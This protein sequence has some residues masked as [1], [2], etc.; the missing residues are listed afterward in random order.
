[1]TTARLRALGIIA[2]LIVAFI[3]I[4][5]TIGWMTLSEEQRQ[6]R[7]DRWHDEDG[8]YR[9]RSVFGDL[10]RSWKRWAE[11]DRSK[12]I[13]LGLDLRGG[14]HMV[15]GFDI[16]ELSQHDRELYEE[17]NY[18]EA[19][20]R[21]EIQK[22]IL[23][24]V[25]RR[26]A[27]FEA[28][29]PVI[30]TLGDSQVQIQLPG[31]KD[32]S[33]AQELI[34]KTAFLGFHI[35]PNATDDR[36]IDALR[37]INTAYP[38]KFTGFLLQ[39][40]PGDPFYRVEEANYPQLRSLLTEINARD[41]LL[42]EGMVMAFGEGDGQVRH[43]YLLNKEPDLTG[44]GLN[45][46]FARPDTESLSGQWMVL[47]ENSGAA[48]TDFGRVTG[49]NIGRNMAI[50]VDGVVVSAPVIQSRISGSGSISGNFDPY[51]AQDLAIALNSG[52]LP[53]PIREDF[54]GVVGA[55]LGE[56]SVKSGVTSALI[57]IAIVMVFMILY[58]R[59]SGIVANISLIVNAL[60]VLAALAY[61]KA[62]LTL[63][64][65]AGLILTV[66]MAVD[67]NVLI[68]ERIREE[69]RNGRS[70]AASIESG[71]ARAQVTILDANITTLIAAAV[72][73]QFG[74]GPIE[75]FAVTLSIGV[76]TSVFTAL[77]LSRAIFDFIVNSNMVSKLGMSSIIKPDTT[78]GFMGASRVAFTFSAICLIGGMSFFFYRGSD[79]FGVDFTTGTNMI[80]HF[81]GNREI[82]VEDVRSKLAEKGMTDVRVQEYVQGTG[83]AIGNGFSIHLGDETGTIGGEEGVSSTVS[84]RAQ[85]ALAELVLDSPTPTTANDA[86]VL[87][88]V[89]TVGPAV[90]DQLKRDAIIAILYSMV[91][92]V[93]YLWYR[94]EYK[95]A[96]AAII[97]VLHDVLFTLGVFAVF[98]RELSLPVIAALLTIIGY[99]LNDTI[100]VFDRIRED[101][102]LYRGR[103]M[104]FSKILNISINQT[105]SRTL[106]TSVTTLFV[107]VVLAVFGGEAIRDF[108]IALSAGVLVG[109]YS[110]IFVASPCVMLLQNWETARNKN[111]LDDDPKGGK[112]GRR[113]RKPKK[114][115]EGAQKEATA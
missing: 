1:M 65:I 80:V 35:V 9:E 91:C 43:L 47:F 93:I 73:F 72:L 40:R 11:F 53:V 92:I 23:N 20:I 2:V 56:E 27:E 10:A 31:E 111:K 61:F 68:F 94:F 109:T 69:L 19:D 26:M 112:G 15:V 38:D 64:G 57:G 8:T 113:R 41:D 34:T 50:V 18:T 48:A 33:R 88:R 6:E 67:A 103:E 66:G 52:S 13:T 54:T 96:F 30:Q 104:K 79:N 77:I 87:D 28:K 100:V 29:E 75:S 102:Q 70:L 76:L 105:L 82:N 17:S 110:S 39:P 24:T 37:A 32:V 42:P 58:Y 115:S 106:L 107:V 95:F 98:Q 101:M 99:S 83:E 46:A 59:V 108:A 55:T 62:T 74:T 97:A 90:G 60:L 63:P 25:E 71:F 86:V 44:E 51:A 4:Y 5:P 12:V 21:Q 36:M 49:E 14:V 22:T 78:V 45:R 85:M 7:L 89:D 81:D 3:Q 84:G 114:S 16:D